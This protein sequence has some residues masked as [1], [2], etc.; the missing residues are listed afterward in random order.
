MLNQYIY[1]AVHTIFAGVFSEVA[2]GTV[3]SYWLAQQLLA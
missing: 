1:Y 3:I 2:N